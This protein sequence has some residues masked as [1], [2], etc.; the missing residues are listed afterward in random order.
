VTGECFA[1]ALSSP[2]TPTGNADAPLI[3]TRPTPAAIKSAK[4]PLRMMSP[5]LAF[6]RSFTSSHSNGA[7]NLLTAR[8]T[9]GVVLKMKNLSS[10][11]NVIAVTDS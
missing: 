2:E 6:G 9:S 8:R 3:P 7:Q 10:Q 1:K 11:I 5:L 4:H